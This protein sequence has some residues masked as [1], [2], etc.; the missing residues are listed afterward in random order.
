MPVALDAQFSRE[1]QGDHTLSVTVSWTLL[2][3]ILTLEV[4]LPRLCTTI[5]LPLWQP[6]SDTDSLVLRTA[7][8]SIRPDEFWYR[9]P[10]RSGEHWVMPLFA[11]STMRPSISTSAAS[12]TRMAAAIG[13]PEEPVAFTF[14]LH[15]V[16][17]APLS[18]SI[19]SDLLMESCS[20]YVPG[21]TRIRLPGVAASMAA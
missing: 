14:I 21:Q 12:L 1:T 8:R 4:S 13:V 5:A 15:G 17:I 11:V 6:L 7:L 19:L 18:P 10:M 16:R 20:R 9:M 2:S 3:S